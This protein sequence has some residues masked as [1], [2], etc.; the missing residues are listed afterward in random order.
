M[1]NSLKYQIKTQEVIK[2][3][4]RPKLSDGQVV[5]VAEDSSFYFLKEAKS[6]ISVQN[7]QTSFEEIAT[8]E[9]LIGTSANTSFSQSSNINLA[10][11]QKLK[12]D[13]LMELKTRKKDRIEEGYRQ[14]YNG[15]KSLSELSSSPVKA[16]KTSTPTANTSQKGPEIIEISLND[17][18]DDVEILEAPSKQV[19]EIEIL[20]DTVSDSDSSD[21]EIVA[22][23]SVPSMSKI[24][25]NFS[26]S[27]ILIKPDDDVDKDDDLVPQP[28]SRPTDKN[29]LQRQK[30]YH[31]ENATLDGNNVESVPR[32]EKDNS[33]NDV[34]AIEPLEVDDNDDITELE[35]VTSTTKQHDPKDT[36]DPKTATINVDEQDENSIEKDEIIA[37]QEN[38]N[39]TVKD[40]VS[41]DSSLHV[42]DDSVHENAGCEND[43]PETESNIVPDDNDQPM[44]VDNEANSDTAVE[45]EKTAEKAIF[46][47]IGQVHYD[48][49]GNIVKVDETPNNKD[50]ITD[51]TPIQKSTEQDV[52]T[53]PNDKDDVIESENEKYVDV[54]PNE[55][56]ETQDDQNIITTKERNKD[57]IENVHVEK[58]QCEENNDTN[59]EETN[60][61]EADETDQEATNDD[62]NLPNK[63]VIAENSNIDSNN[64]C[65]S[66]ND[67]VDNAKNESLEENKPEEDS[68]IEA[69][70]TTSE[71]SD[72]ENVEIPKT[73]ANQST[74]EKISENISFEKSPMITL[75]HTSQNVI[76]KS[77]KRCNTTKKDT[78]RISNLFSTT[79]ECSKNRKLQALK[80]IHNFPPFIEVIPSNYEEYQDGVFVCKICPKIILSAGSCR[81]HIF[82]I[83]DDNYE[84][85]PPQP[86][87]EIMKPMTI[88]DNHD[89][90]EDST[91]QDDMDQQ[92]YDPGES[93]TNE[94]ISDNETNSTISDEEK[95][96]CKPTVTAPTETY[97]R[98]FGTFDLSDFEDF[99]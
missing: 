48:V 59:D 54:V 64:E 76:K 7:F 60:M 45:N 14:K 95:N 81:S 67:D 97:P 34:V 38:D 85:I 6:T 98:S 4:L 82:E 65:G 43:T 89:I 1:T 39:L 50:T 16:K 69:M 66:L 83:H 70:D 96:E 42:R 10:E 31:V 33:K 32:T 18:I 55:H 79:K 77:S 5:L 99:E 8:K 74:S 53:K 22:D 3:M 30:H 94:D 23:V 40:I 93:N 68:Q 56:N 61:S 13:S 88:I 62:Q 49:H 80:M 63:D 21:I 37:E 57:D 92:A 75:G 46:R 35:L 86:Q 73:D 78:F 12:S 44:E 51:M 29:D 17:S 24:V 87:S 19:D 2:T 15:I 36:N 47:Q 11:L 71:S 58:E 41:N 26:R 84:Q 52:H 28:S 20:D 9:S 72:K 25:E 91:V 90:T 27:G